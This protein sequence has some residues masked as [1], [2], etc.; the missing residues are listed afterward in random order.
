MDIYSEFPPL[1]RDRINQ[2]A[3]VS[4]A[5]SFFIVRVFWWGWVNYAFWH[6]VVWALREP[7]SPSYGV[8]ITGTMFLI[9]NA[10]LTCLQLKWGW[11]IASAI[12]DA[13]RPN[14]KEK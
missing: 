4:F 5:I 13:V 7:T 9:G 11:T 10:F 14:R 6:D 2:I 3:R 1:K 8:Y 12:A